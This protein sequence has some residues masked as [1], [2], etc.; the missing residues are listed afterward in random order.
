MTVLSGVITGALAAG[1]F[2]GI[3]LVAGLA[4]TRWVYIQFQR[5]AV[6]RAAPGWIILFGTWI[7]KARRSR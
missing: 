6:T 7:L 5:R 4:L 3:G 2:G 1:L